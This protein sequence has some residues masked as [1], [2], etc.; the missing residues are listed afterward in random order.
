M[1]D[2]KLPDILWFSD[3]HLLPIDFSEV[4]RVDLVIGVGDYAQKKDYY[5]QKKFRVNEIEEGLI[6]LK[7]NIDEVNPKFGS[8]LFHGN[9]EKEYLKKGK[10]EIILKSMGLLNINS[11]YAPVVYG[12]NPTQDYWLFVQS[13]NPDELEEKITKRTINDAEFKCLVG[14]NMNLNN[15]TSNFDMAV[16]AHVHNRRDKSDSSPNIYVSIVNNIKRDKIGEP[17]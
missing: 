13:M 9:H 15:F 4:N 2:E 11:A 16:G 12:K 6:D 10:N 3:T 17:V 1:L 8:I 5:T 14:H 7:N